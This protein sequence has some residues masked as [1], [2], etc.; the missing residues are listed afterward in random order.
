MTEALAATLQKFNRKERYWVIKNALGEQGCGQGGEP[1]EPKLKLS[2][3]FYCRL[4][5]ALGGSIDVVDSD[6]VWWAVDYHLDWLFAA[7]KFHASA[8]DERTSNRWTNERPGG[9]EF[10]ELEGQQ[11]DIDLLVVAGRCVIFVEAKAYTG[12][13]P[14]QLRRKIQR[15]ENLVQDE[16]GTIKPEYAGSLGLSL[17][18]VFMSI[19]GPPASNGDKSWPEWACGS[20]GSPAWLRLA[21]HQPDLVLVPVRCNEVRK[22]YSKGEYWTVKTQRAPQ[23]QSKKSKAESPG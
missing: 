13:D 12:W 1:A 22:A 21:A 14:E 18:F 10:R 7:L 16:Q 6:E 5:E 19:D 15:I 3:G 23:T 9:S 8:A 17:R 11:E 20:A 2:P 4:Q